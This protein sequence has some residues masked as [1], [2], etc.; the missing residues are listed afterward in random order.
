MVITD[1]TRLSDAF[2]KDL[3]FGF[4]E[5]YFNKSSWKTNVIC[6][7]FGTILNVPRS[8]V[9]KDLAKQNHGYVANM[10]L[11]PNSANFFRNK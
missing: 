9:I 5:K 10:T 4:L 11:N 2:L 7:N 6:A 1:H 3:D 8:I